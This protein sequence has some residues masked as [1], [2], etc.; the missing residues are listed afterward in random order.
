MSKQENK[1]VQECLKNAFRGKHNKS[2]GLQTKRGI[3]KKKRK[4]KTNIGRAG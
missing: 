1:T 3:S 2:F 4:T